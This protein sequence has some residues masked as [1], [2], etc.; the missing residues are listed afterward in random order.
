MM[1]FHE[2]PAFVAPARTERHLQPDGS[3]VLRSPEALGPYARC[4]GEWIERWSAETPDALAL[5]ERVGAERWRRVRWGELRH[6]VGAIGQRLIDLG[7]PR[8]QPIVILSD[9]AIDNAMLMFAAMHVGLPVCTVS[10]AYCRLTQDHTKVR[11]ILDTLRPSLVYA[12]NAKVY[13]AAMTASAGMAI[14]VL[15]E[16]AAE[17]PGALDFASFL[18]TRETAAV[19]DAFERI[20]AD[21]VAKYLL[22]SGS[23]GQ[24]KVVINTHRM[25]CA[26]QQSLAQTWPFLEKM[27]PVLLDWLPWSHTFGGNHNLNLV[28][29]NGGALYIDDGRPVPGLIE[30]TVRNLRDVRPN[31]HFNVPRGLEMLLPFLEVD[32]ELAREILSPLLLVFY[33]AAALPSATWERLQRLATQVRSEPLWLTTSWGSTETSPLVTSA[34][35]GLDGPGCIGVPVPGLEL[36]LVKVGEKQEMRVR[37]VSVFPGYRN[38]PALTEAAFDEEGFYKIG[39][40]GYLVDPDDP[41]RGVVFDGRVAEDFKL[42]TGT[43]VSV[44]PL[45]LAVVSALSPFAQDVVITGH[46]RNEIGLLIFPSAAAVK[47]PPDVVG[48][49]IRQALGVF[50]QRGA[51]SSQA[52]RRAMLLMEPPNADAGEITDK[53]YLNQR[54]VLARRADLVSCLYADDDDAL[55]IRV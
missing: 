36:K 32:A 46:D 27:K 11:G 16:G 19:A 8:D 18:A 28:L 30:S 45:R 7:L 23:T 3:I 42:T 38:A 15:S 43:W 39:D 20:A 49:K 33:A 51:G 2:N 26:N 53:G 40:A 22:T 5:A 54:A 25:L 1:A 34:H 48:E 41:A 50:Q 9:N 21:D 37:G 52:P 55:V 14:K 10:S 24:P 47:A 4:I 13:G 29:R 6:A 35:F 12:S 31:L 44:G 17:L